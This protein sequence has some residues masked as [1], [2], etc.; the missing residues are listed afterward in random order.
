MALGCK[1]SPNP[2]CKRMGALEP[3]PFRGVCEP[4]V[5]AIV[6]AQE[7][8]S[9]SMAISRR[10]STDISQGKN[11]SMSGGTWPPFS[12]QLVRYHISQVRMLTELCLFD[13]AVEL[14]ERLHREVPWVVEARSPRD[15]A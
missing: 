5:S 10:F 3:F 9:G 2:L 7:L 11:G 6:P 4:Q 12:A 13:A 15:P 14:C 1:A 8:S